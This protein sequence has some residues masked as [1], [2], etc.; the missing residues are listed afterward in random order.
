M[1]LFYWIIPLNEND[2][3]ICDYL[4]ENVYNKRITVKDIVFENLDENLIRKEFSPLSSIYLF[5]VT[6]RN[7]E[8]DEIK[9]IKEVFKKIPSNYRIEI[10]PVFF[11]KQYT[12]QSDK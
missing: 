10:N 8:N 9:K 12:I 11:T 1:T 2:K 5:P 4:K 7:L 6:I 3:K